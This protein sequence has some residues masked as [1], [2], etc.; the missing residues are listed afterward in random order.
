MF[1]NKY[2][3]RFSEIEHFPEAKYHITVPWPSIERQLDS[4]GE[5]QGVDL[6]PDF[7]RGH[8][9]TPEQQT[10]YVEYQLRMGET[11]RTIWWA[12]TRWGSPQPGP[13]Q[14]LDG[15][16]RLTAVR[17]FMAN[18]LPA[19]GRLKNEFQDKMRPFQYHLDFNVVDLPDRAA[20]LRAYLAFNAGGV[21]HAKTELERVR[22]LLAN[23]CDG[24]P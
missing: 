17:E 8:V 3:T 20:V 4:W 13:M 23:E 6:C 11:A 1:T 21:V 9:W 16:Q 14:L 12:C 19:F 2:P 15:L 10:A 5:D 24:T 22:A 7:Q 18:R